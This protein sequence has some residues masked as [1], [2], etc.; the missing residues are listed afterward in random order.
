MLGFLPELVLM[1]LPPL[2]SC[3]VPAESPEAPRR[4]WGYCTS[5]FLLSIVVWELMAFSAEGMGFVSRVQ[6]GTWPGE[7]SS[8]LAPSLS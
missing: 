4:L 5:R 8:C 6:M 1:T 3:P 2:F 7:G